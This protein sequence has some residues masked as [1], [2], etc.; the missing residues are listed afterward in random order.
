[1]SL[2]AEVMIEDTA[3]PGHNEAV[4]EAFKRVDLVLEVEAVW[5]RK[6]ADILPWVV[7]VAVDGTLAGFFGALG[8]NA[9]SKFKR[10][11]HDLR[12]ARTGAG[13]GTGSIDISDSDNTHLILPDSLP[14]EALDALR[15]VDWSEKRGEY[16]VW[17]PNR[18]EWVDPLKRGE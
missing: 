6:S 10:L 9:Y 12:E 8:V 5:M 13:D 15:D 4:A 1:M 18:H 17:K 2:L 16:L 14:D 7:K 3:P 11:V